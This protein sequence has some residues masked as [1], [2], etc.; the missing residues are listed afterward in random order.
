MEAEARAACA[1]DGMEAEVRA[2]CAN[3]F[4]SD[5]THPQ[6]SSPQYRRSLQVPHRVDSSSPLPYFPRH[7]YLR[8]RTFT[9]DHAALASVDASLYSR[10]IVS[11]LSPVMAAFSRKFGTGRYFLDHM[12]TRPGELDGPTT[13]G[14]RSSLASTSRRL[15][16]AGA[17]LVVDH[18]SFASTVA[19][20]CSRP[21]ALRP[22][23]CHGCL[24]ASVR[25]RPPLPRPQEDEADGELDG[26]ATAGVCATRS[27]P[28]TRER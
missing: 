24:L 10:L 14:M 22:H 21:A 4:K 1:D 26:P 7:G 23:H 3:N 5:P 6:R 17:P 11:P 28:S 2:A 18:V 25:H 16:I 15:A 13:A 9:L 19:G 8:H 27:Q 20:L 12:K